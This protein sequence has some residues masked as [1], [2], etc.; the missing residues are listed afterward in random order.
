MQHRTINLLQEAVNFISRYLLVFMAINSAKGCIR[1]EL[2]DLAKNLSVSL[3]V[4]LSLSDV[5]EQ[6]S[7]AVLCL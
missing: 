7:Q 1:L 4:E 2:K 5:S 6:V 3:D